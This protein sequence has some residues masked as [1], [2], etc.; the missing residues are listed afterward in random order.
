[1]KLSATKVFCESL[2]T[3]IFKKS[4]VIKIPRTKNLKASPRVCARVRLILIAGA[5]G[6][7][8]FELI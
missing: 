2:S 3:F 6:A 5:L 8:S 4:F 1:M 7:F